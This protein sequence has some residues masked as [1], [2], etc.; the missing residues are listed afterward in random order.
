M[1][2]EVVGSNP[3]TYLINSNFTLVV[4]KNKTNL[5]HSKLYL[6]VYLISTW[7][8]QYRTAQNLNLYNIIQTA[9]NTN[10]QNLLSYTK[11][12]HRDMHKVGSTVGYCG[13]GKSQVFLRKTFTNY[14]HIGLHSHSTLFR[15]H[16][17]FQ[18]MYI[19]NTKKGSITLNINR[20]FS[21]YINVVSYISN[22]SHYNLKPLIFGTVFFKNEIYALN[23]ITA[24]AIKLSTRLNKLLLFVLP[25]SRNTYNQNTVKLL[26]EY[27]TNNAIIL[28]VLYHKTTVQYLRRLSIFSLGI[29]PTTYD[30][31]SVDLVIPVSSDNI[32]SQLFILKLINSI[33]K[34]SEY[35]KYVQNLS[36]WNKYKGV[37]CW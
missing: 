24:P 27:K 2:L 9:N 11:N 22:T 34:Q 19:K 14:I 1:A 5:L 20:L 23:W 3:T 6:C 25:I 12:I 37:S 32:F 10:L 7:G 29:V 16:S 17:T 31:K 18:S 15:V 4:N 21:N 13:N 28:D 36:L 30:S 33:N 35:G 8:S 26:L